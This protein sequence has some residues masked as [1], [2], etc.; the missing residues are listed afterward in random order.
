MKIYTATYIEQDGDGNP[1]LKLDL[2]PYKSSKLAIFPANITSRPQINLA[3]KIH[4]YSHETSTEMKGLLADAGMMTM[5]MCEACDKVSRSCAVCAE[6][7]IPATYKKISLTNVN[8]AFNQ[9]I[10]AYFVIIYLKGEKYE[11]LNIINAETRYGEQV[12]EI[13]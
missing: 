7:D 2:E 1:K 8:R 9:S 6:T 4:C 12:M 5:E 11:V 10:Q 3:K 13:F